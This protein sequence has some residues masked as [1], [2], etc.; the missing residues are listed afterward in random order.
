MWQV[1]SKGGRRVKR[2]DLE[3]EVDG[4][5]GPREEGGVSVSTGQ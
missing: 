5:G 2:M 1:D 3:P 4:L